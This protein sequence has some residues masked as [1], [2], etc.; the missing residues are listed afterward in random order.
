LRRDAAALPRKGKMR[1]ET[2]ATASAV[3]KQKSY[4]QIRPGRQIIYAQ[5]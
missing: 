1:C 4:A 3:A 2:A 5:I